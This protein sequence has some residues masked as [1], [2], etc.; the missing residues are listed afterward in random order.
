MQARK[1]GRST[2][3][4]SVIQF[5][6]LPETLE[7]ASATEPE[8]D[9]STGI[10]LRKTKSQ[11]RRI[12]TSKLQR[13]RIVHDLPEACCQSCQGDLIKMGEDVSEQLEYIPGSLK[14]IEHVRREILPAFLSKT[15]L[16]GLYIAIDRNFKCH[17]F[18]NQRLFLQSSLLC[19]IPNC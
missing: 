3:Q 8:E 9:K 19:P 6:W 11:G 14:V 18:Q 13:E 2:E 12:D 4:S 16:L 7:E 5:D 17:F 1:F 15:S 10:P